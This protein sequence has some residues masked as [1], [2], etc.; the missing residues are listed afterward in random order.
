MWYVLMRRAFH[1]FTLHRLLWNLTLHCCVQNTL[2][3]DAVLLYEY[4]KAVHLPIF[5]M[6]RSLVAVRWNSS[7]RT[8]M[9]QTSLVVWWSELL[10]TNHEVPGLIP[11]CT[12]VIF[13]VGG[14]SPL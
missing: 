1:S 5:G 4:I 11:G 9:G 10:T 2:S 13:L 12:M 6:F 8:I 14:G 7:T 3:Q